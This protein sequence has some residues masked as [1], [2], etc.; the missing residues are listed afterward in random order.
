MID[1]RAGEDAR[2]GAKFKRL[3]QLSF[4][5]ISAVRTLVYVIRGD[6]KITLQKTQPAGGGHN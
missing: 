4:V 5:M 2:T 6:A 3:S 1:I